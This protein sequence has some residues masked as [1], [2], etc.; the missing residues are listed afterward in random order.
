MKLIKIKLIFQLSVVTFLTSCGNVG[1]E[2]E[3]KL[4]DLK[5]KTESLDSLVNKEVD[6]V[7]T[8]DSLIIEESN[9]VKK[10]DTLINKTTSKLD[11]LAG[12]G[13]KLNKK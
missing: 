4:N 11:S 7:L 6:K 12:K 1:S 3:N 5:K 2:V 13:S 9:K 8:L 10:L